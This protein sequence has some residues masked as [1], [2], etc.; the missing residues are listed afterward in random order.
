[1]A[2]QESVRFL[3]GVN[4]I[5]KMMFGAFEIEY[6]ESHVSFGDIERQMSIAGFPPE[7]EMRAELRSKKI[8][9]PVCAKKVTDGLDDLKGIESV[10]VDVEKK[11]VDVA[12]DKSQITLDD[13]KS[14]VEELGYPAD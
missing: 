10:N 2:V 1:M 11:S 13:I 12:F 4:N 5:D 8:M 14:K 7:D 6:N 3:S 9:C